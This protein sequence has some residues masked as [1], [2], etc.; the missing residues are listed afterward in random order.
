MNNQKFYLII[1]ALL[2]LT[3]SCSKIKDKTEA[4]FDINQKYVVDKIEQ[5]IDLNNNCYSHIIVLPGTGCSGCINKAEIFFKNNIY[6]PNYLFILTDFQSLKILNHKLGMDI[7]NLKNVYIDNE[8][9]FKN[10]D[11]SVYPAFLTLNCKTKSITNVTFQTPDS[12]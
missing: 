1:F 7:K 11:Y 8:N 2:S 4:N 6:Q 10:Y 9:L 12:K 3:L 5:I